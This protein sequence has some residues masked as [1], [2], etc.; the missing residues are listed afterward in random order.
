MKI[1][2][3]GIVAIFIGLLIGLIIT[4]GILRAKKALDNSPQPGNDSDTPPINNPQE[5]L[6]ESSLFLEIKAPDDN[7]IVKNNSI[8]LEGQTLPD[9]YIAIITE[10]NEYLIVPS[11]TGQFTQDIALIKG[12]NTISI[13][14]YTETGEKVE[15][16]INVVYTSA[17]I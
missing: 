15:K 3:E 5:T 17:E 10:K 1:K 6:E 11:E 7:V 16:T 14:V 12:A 13:T 9:T 4:G 2:K 8:N